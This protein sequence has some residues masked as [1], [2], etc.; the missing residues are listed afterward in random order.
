MAAATQE[1]TALAATVLPDWLPIW[2]QMGTAAA[3]TAAEA[4]RR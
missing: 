4:N 3:K 1:G 2:A